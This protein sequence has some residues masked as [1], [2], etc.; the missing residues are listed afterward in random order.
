MEKAEAELKE[1][2]AADELKERRAVADVELKILALQNQLLGEELFVC[3]FNPFSS[4][5]VI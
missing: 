5:I 1:R 3:V 4:H 2:R